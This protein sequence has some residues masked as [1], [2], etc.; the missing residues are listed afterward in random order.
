MSDVRAKFYVVSVIP[1]DRDNENGGAKVEL[2]PVYSTDPS[3]ENKSFWDAT[4][5]GG[6]WMNIS[7]PTAAKAFKEGAQYYVDFTEA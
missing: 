1:Y 2:Q 4:P 5:S 7:N 3:H 6:I